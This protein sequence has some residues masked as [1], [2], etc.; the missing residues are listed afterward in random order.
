MS[1]LGNLMSVGRVIGGVVPK[2]E[3]S[4]VSTKNGLPSINVGAQRAFGNGLTSRVQS[5]I[6]GRL[7][8]KT[9]QVATSPVS[10]HEEP[11]LTR[12][13]LPAPV[14]PVSIASIPTEA[15]Q[16]RTSPNPS[17]ESAGSGAKSPEGVKSFELETELALKRNARGRGRASSTKSPPDFETL[18]RPTRWSRWIRRVAFWRRVAPA[19]ATWIQSEFSLDRVRPMRNGLGDEED[20]GCKSDGE[21]RP[22]Q[23]VIRLKTVNPFMTPEEST[24]TVT[25]LPSVGPIS[26][27]E[28]ECKSNRSAATFGLSA[29]DFT[30]ATSA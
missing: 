29:T 2:T 28:Q 12:A 3:Y 4:I 25:P 16:T 8:S 11:R 27:G 1:L 13:T 23:Q 7:P 5:E 10:V 26:K 20:Q 21:G 30:S 18:A 6:Q 14:S 15:I 9:A 24:S 19:S 22:A 17:G